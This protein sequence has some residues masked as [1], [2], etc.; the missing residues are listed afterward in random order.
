MSEQSFLTAAV[1]NMKRMVCFAR[2]YVIFIFHYLKPNKPAALVSTTGFSSTQL[3]NESN[4]RRLKWA[5]YAECTLNDSSERMSYVG[6]SISR[7]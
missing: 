2:L 3:S 6:D 5:L 4:S 1:Q 7:T